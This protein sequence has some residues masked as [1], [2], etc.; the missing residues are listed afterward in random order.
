[1]Q[2]NAFLKSKLSYGLWLSAFILLSIS[3]SFLFRQVPINSDTASYFLQA[4]DI[5]NGNIFLKG[6]TL[7]ADNYYTLDTA[8]LSI[9]ML[10]TGSS[11]K[12]FYI[13]PAMV[14]ALI[15]L[16]SF[17]LSQANQF[18]WR[19]A[20][21]MVMIGMPTLEA[22]S[23]S[24]GLIAYHAA[25]LMYCLLILFCIQNIQRPK[26]QLS[27]CF[28]LTYLL[29]AGDP[30]ADFVLVLPLFILFLLEY[31]RPD[32]LPGPRYLPVIMLTACLLAHISAY[33]FNGFSLTVISP[34]NSGI[35]NGKEMAFNSL[36]FIINLCT[37]SGSHAAAPLYFIIIRSLGLIAIIWGFCKSLMNWNSQDWL[38]M[39]LAISIILMSI[40]FIL[41]QNSCNSY[42]DIAPVDIYSGRYLIANYV[43]GVILAART[44]KLQAPA[45]K[46]LAALALA[47]N[48]YYFVPTL[49]LAP[50]SASITPAMQWLEKHGY[51]YGYGSYWDSSL[52]TVLSSNKLLVRPI[53]YSFNTNQIGPSF[54]LSDKTWYSKQSK[55][56]NSFVLFK[57]RSYKDR[58]NLASLNAR[59]GQ[60]AQLIFIN[61]YSIAIWNKDIAKVWQ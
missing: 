11:L 21:I 53:N 29:C 56:A 52:A 20:F 46:W 35:G 58:I 59:F 12:L 57:V 13:I 49:F 23:N 3:Y 43:F 60:P 15:V 27:L 26:L 61:G 9:G 40:A 51:S 22:A 32:S 42:I 8:F 54:W 36:F 4:Q 38:N 34:V 28:L 2:L 14:F 19:S 33:L 31:R 1:M 18:F 55:Q 6:W 39:F 24:F 45:W 30:W 10:L 41:S 44:F 37:L 50:A 7:S 47:L 5:V 25:S 17:S 16:L 48:L